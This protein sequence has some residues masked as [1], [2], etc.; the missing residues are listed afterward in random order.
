LQH[1]RLLNL[2]QYQWQNIVEFY[3]HIMP[4][5]PANITAIDASSRTSAA[6]IRPIRADKALEA[7]T[8]SSASMASPRE[9]SCTVPIAKNL[10]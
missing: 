7:M 8:A 6:S 1:L 4:H 3:L 5:K 9:K 2:N 10:D